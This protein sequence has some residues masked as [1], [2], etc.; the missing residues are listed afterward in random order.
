MKKAFKVSGVSLAG[1]GGMK[2]EPGGGGGGCVRPGVQTC[3]D[4]FLAAEELRG[5][6]RAGICHVDINKHR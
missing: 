3:L 2:G 1:Q 6:S 5:G 4:S